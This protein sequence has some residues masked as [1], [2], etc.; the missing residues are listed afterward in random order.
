MTSAQLR[1]GN[2]PIVCYV[3]D[4]RSL[5]DGGAAALLEKIA[6]AAAAGADFLQ[7]REKDLPSDELLALIREAIRTV[8]TAASR[9]RVIVN[10]R[11]DLALAGG[12]AGVHLGWES[13]PPR[14]VLN[15][16]RQG[17]APAEF[18]VGVSCH[19]IEEAR[20]ADGMGASYA[21]FGHVFATPSKR[22]FGSP[23]SLAELAKVC[24]AVQIPVLAIGGVNLGNAADCLRAGAA[25]VAAI[26][27]FQQ[28]TDSEVL[29]AGIGRL[30]G[31]GSRDLEI[32]R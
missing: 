3:T 17:N 12:A 18:L 2:P 10:D 13:A 31:S 26:R 25:G 20:E 14:D 28:P 11:L 27:L 22:Q 24:R 4:R 21:F 15:W 8:Q 1:K 30:H 9:T 29:K 7:I 5:S 32:R 6:A 23:Q 19:S 16:C